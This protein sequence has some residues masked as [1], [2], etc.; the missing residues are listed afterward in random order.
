MGNLDSLALLV[1][2]MEATELGCSIVPGDR[3]ELHSLVVAVGNFADIVCETVS[4][5]L[6]CVHRWHYG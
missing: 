6:S 3:S 4:G 1:L 2:D 5:G